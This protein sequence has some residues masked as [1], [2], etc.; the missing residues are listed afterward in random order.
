MPPYVPKYV[1]PKEAAAAK[2]RRRSLVFWIAVAIPLVVLLLLFGY[3]DQA[4]EFL[5]RL[6]ITVDG[7]MG[8]PVLKLIGWLA[9]K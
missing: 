6:T 7:A 3:S 1:S 9:A 2:A 5:R 4:P 8:L